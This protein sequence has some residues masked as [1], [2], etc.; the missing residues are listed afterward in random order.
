MNKEYVTC[1]CNETLF[2]YKKNEILSFVAMWMDQHSIILNAMSD[3]KR[4][5]LCDVTY[6]ESKKMKQMNVYSLI[7]GWPKSS[8]KFFR[9]ILWKNPNELFGQPN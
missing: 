9:N 3:R 5:I 7:L 8:F 6:M 2:R 4:Q 1:I